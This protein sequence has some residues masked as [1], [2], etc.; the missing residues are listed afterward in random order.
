MSTFR[1]YGIFAID[2]EISKLSLLREIAND[3]LFMATRH[4]TEGWRH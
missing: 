3:K 4:P 1:M 2:I